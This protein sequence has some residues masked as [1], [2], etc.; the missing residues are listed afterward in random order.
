ME[1]A[2]AC[3]LINYNSGLNIDD[4]YTMTEP[5]KTPLTDLDPE[6]ILQ[7]IGW[8]PSNLEQIK[9]YARMSPAKKVSQML[10]LRSE[11]M[12]HTRARL[13][14]THPDYTNVELV[15]MEQEQI[16]L[17]KKGFRA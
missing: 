6:A 17:M 3:Q 12:R 4:G 1:R 2:K 9:A 16:A 14:A 13:S 11:L 15:L 8:H 10:H 7:R 5:A